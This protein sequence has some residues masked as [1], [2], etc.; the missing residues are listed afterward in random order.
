M[1]TTILGGGEKEVTG[2]PIEFGYEFRETGGTEMSKELIPFGGYAAHQP[3]C[4]YSP[5][6][7][8]ATRECGNR[9]C[10]K[11]RV[12]QGGSSGTYQVHDGAY[13]CRGRIICETIYA[14]DTALKQNKAQL[15]ELYQA[16]VEQGKKAEWFRTQQNKLRLS[17]DEVGGKRRELDLS[18]KNTGADRGADISWFHRASSKPRD[19]N[20]MDQLLPTGLLPVP[21][22][23]WPNPSAS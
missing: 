18:T 16:L 21:N 14:Y 2:R 1:T 6:H 23:G 15:S 12:G 10:R 17:N 4:Q 19:A 3:A 20:W 9:N 7:G 5:Q 8:P 22:V 13:S 11:R